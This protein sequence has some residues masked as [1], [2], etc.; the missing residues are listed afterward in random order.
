LKAFK[1]KTPVKTRGYLYLVEAAGLV[2]SGIGVSAY[3][4]LCG[5]TIPLGRSANSHCRFMVTITLL[6]LFS[7]LLLLSRN[8]CAYSA[9]TQLIPYHRGVTPSQFRGFEVQVQPFSLYKI[10]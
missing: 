10:L 2:G 3:L 6:V 8:I 4:K 1:R 7:F 5:P 9:A